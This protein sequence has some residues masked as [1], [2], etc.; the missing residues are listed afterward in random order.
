MRRSFFV[1]GG[2][3]IAARA[4]GDG[5]RMID[6]APTLA[7]MLGVAAPASAQGRA[8]LDALAL[9][10]PARAALAA[11]DDARGGHATAAAAA[12]RAPLR[13]AEQRA[14]LLRLAGCVAVLA[15][16]ALAVRRARHAARL[17]LAC[18]AAAL[19]LTAAA[20]AVRF[21]APSFSAD[22]TS[23]RLAYATALIAAAACA[24]AFAPA[25]VAIVRRRLS[26]AHAAAAALG[27]TAGA[28]P[29]AMVAFVIA[30]ASAPRLACE[31]GWLAAL[32]LVAY[33][34]LVP[35][36]LAAALLVG[37]AVSMEAVAAIVARLLQHTR[38]QPDRDRADDGRHLSC[39]PRSPACRRKR[40]ASRS[41]LRSPA[42][43][44]LKPRDA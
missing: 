40:R 8:W 6:V 7:A 18:G 22:R 37:V 4:R 12:A 36:L 24:V 9:P 26:A 5:M 11:A 16:V 43:R 27:A 34:A 33:V 13:S 35:A 44:R 19:T 31:P 23:E 3:A 14:R 15:A 42:H 38:L 10:A 2:P 30:G 28:A 29:A 32:P 1:A 20:F 41:R 21:G 17:G 25:F 39:I